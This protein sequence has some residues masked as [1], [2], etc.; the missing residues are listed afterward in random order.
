MT[1]HLRKKTKLLFGVGI[2]DADYAVKP[3]INGKEVACPFY[4]T[5]KS[6]LYRCYSEGIRKERPTYIGCSVADEWLLF[7]KFK[8][9]MVNQ[10]WEGKALD[11]DILIQG[12][13]VYS[14]KTCIFVSKPINNLLNKHSSLRGKYPIGVDLRRK[15]NKYRAKCLAYGKST[16]IGH[17][18]T[19]EEAHEA[20]KK[21]KYKHIAEIANQQSEPL[22]T[23]LLN[24]KIEG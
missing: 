19:P 23:A 14:P 2:N 1:K 7:S 17:Y 5:W 20:Y 16:H 12:N 10:C 6:M 3:T 18:D 8:L 21:F 13:K 9:W 15:K 4:L 24:Y 22:R 11:K